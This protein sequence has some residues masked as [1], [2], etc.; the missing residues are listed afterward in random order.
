MSREPYEKPEVQELQV[1]DLIDEASRLLAHSMLHLGSAMVEVDRISP[2]IDQIVCEVA[3]AMSDIE[4]AKAA[5]LKIDAVI[6]LTRRG[7]VQ[8]QG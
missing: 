6:D 7:D 3:A 8:D 1:G 5:K 4:K 2:I